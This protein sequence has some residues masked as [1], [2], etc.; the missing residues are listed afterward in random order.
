MNELLLANEEDLL[1]KLELANLANEG[2]GMIPDK[3]V[4]I[5]RI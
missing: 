1:I 4:P 3:L 5:V 2:F